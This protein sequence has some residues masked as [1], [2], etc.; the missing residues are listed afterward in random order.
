MNRRGTR[1]CVAGTMSDY[2]AVVTRTTFAYK[3]IPV[4]DKPYWA[5]NDGSGRKCFV[6]ISGDDRVA[7]ISY[8]TRREIASVK[9]GDHPQRMRM[10]RVRRSSLRG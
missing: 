6:S 3:I 4:G 2:V 1:L 9:V 5:T 7:V 8:R 10:G